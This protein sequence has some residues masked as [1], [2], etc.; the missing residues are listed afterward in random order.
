MREFEFSQADFLER[1]NEL[2]AELDHLLQVN[3][4][5]KQRQVALTEFEA[6]R[7]EMEAANQQLKNELNN[8]KL[9]LKK[10]EQMIQEQKQKLEESLRADREAITQ[11]SRQVKQL[12]LD[13][14]EQRIQ[15]AYE[16]QKVY[17]EVDKDRK[18]TENLMDQS[19][20]VR[21]EKIVSS[22]CLTEYQNLNY[23]QAKRITDL[24]SKL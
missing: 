14:R 22:D 23:R 11:M 12:D 20:K 24:K 2:K 17:L 15:F 6:R 18:L 1:Q 9:E 8:E 5:L 21:M 19:K 3:S 13:T 10:K 7:P 16:K 4:E